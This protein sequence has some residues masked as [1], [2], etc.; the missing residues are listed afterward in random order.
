MWNKQTKWLLAGLLAAGM[1]NACSGD[2][3]IEDCADV[4]N[5]GICDV[6]EP[7]HGQCD[8]E[9]RNQQGVCPG[10]VHCTGVEILVDGEC[11]ACPTGQVAVNNVCETPSVTCE[12][13]EIIVNDECVECEEDETATDNQCV[14]HCSNTQIVVN[15]TC[16]DCAPGEVNDGNNVC[17]PESPCDD[18]DET[19][20]D[21]ACCVD[22]NENGLCDA[23][24]PG[25][26]TCP[27]EERDEFG[28]CP[29]VCHEDL[30][31]EPGVCECL[32]ADLDGLCDSSDDDD[33]FGLLNGQD[34]DGD[35]F[36][37]DTDCLDIMATTYPGAP[38]SCGDVMVNDCDHPCWA[39]NSC[40]TLIESVKEGR[41]TL[42]YQEDLQNIVEDVSDLFTDP[43]FVLE[44]DTTA[45]LSFC[46]NTTFS[47]G[48][49]VSGEGSTVDIGWG[50]GNPTLNR[51]MSDGPVVE[52][53]DGAWVSIDGLNFSHDPMATGAHAHGIKCVNAILGVGD[54]DI[55]HNH[56]GLGGGIYGEKCDLRVN[57]DLSIN[58]NRAKLGSAIYLGEESFSIAGITQVTIAGNV[59]Q[60]SDSGAIHL[61]NSTMDWVNAF[62]NPTVSWRGNHLVDDANTNRDVY[63][64]NTSEFAVSEATFLGPQSDNVFVE[65][66]NFLYSGT[67]TNLACS[68]SGCQP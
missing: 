39:D 32:D 59:V 15:N 63:L 13:N 34:E 60:A 36:C 57:S 58:G 62:A 25:D 52:V 38:E 66:Q 35:G 14:P 54:L 53:R 37:A 56:A 6:N 49:R 46:G 28:E 45:S 23:D 50:Y 10:T 67:I 4:N 20:I 44:I 2:D 48:V 41:A 40:A 24:E 43:D 51:G 21:G 42:R 8:A 68:G 27:V 29:T 16:I 30:E 61:V 33:C 11:E 18:P 26:G 1:M 9:D 7:G 5:N 17:E 3:P 31:I 65:T 64:D 55:S 12:A 19:F 22:A 47:G